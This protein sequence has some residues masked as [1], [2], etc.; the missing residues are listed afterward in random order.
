MYKTFLK[1]QCKQHSEI[2][3]VAD[4]FFFASIQFELM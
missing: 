2:I 1:L 4:L 3:V